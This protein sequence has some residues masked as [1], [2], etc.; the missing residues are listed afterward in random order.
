MS[1]WSGLNNCTSFKFNN[2]KQDIIPVNQAHISNVDDT[3]NITPHKQFKASWMDQQ[4][5]SALQNY[6]DVSSDFAEEKAKIKFNAV[7]AL[8][9]HQSSNSK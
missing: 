5:T 4:P 8:E 3:C 2:S 9:Q 1:K 7:V 6:E